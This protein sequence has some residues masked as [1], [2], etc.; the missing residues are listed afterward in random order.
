[1]HFGFKQVKYTI[2]NMFSPSTQGHKYLKYFSRALQPQQVCLLL[3]GNKQLESGSGIKI[4]KKRRL[5]RAVKVAGQMLQ[6][7]SY[8]A[9]IMKVHGMVRG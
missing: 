2:L 8:V 4:K 7:V 9:L 5:T 1:M 6:M 3:S